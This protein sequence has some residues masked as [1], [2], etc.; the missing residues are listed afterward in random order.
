MT[1]Q[2]CPEI[3]E[4]VIGATYDTQPIANVLHAK[5]PGGYTQSDI[6]N[7][8]TAVDAWVGSDYRALMN[9]HV[10]YNETRAKGLT[11][12]I[13][14]QSVVNT[15]AGAGTMGAG[16]LPGNV[17]LCIT[18]RT[19]FTGRSARGRVYMF[20]FDGAAQ[21]GINTVSTAYA[22]NCAAALNALLGA[23]VGVGWTPVILSRRTAGAL[24][25]TGIGTA[26]TIAEA[27]NT[28]DD[29]QRGRPPRNH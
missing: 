1:F 28:E 17:C 11:N 8:A 12:I 16:A 14:L 7:L 25:T 6:D 18:L 15:N 29:S 22:N 9:T 23:V 27:R 5:L 4:Y 19:A 3:A 13:D 21:T 2:S 10:T 20:P 24:R 26:I